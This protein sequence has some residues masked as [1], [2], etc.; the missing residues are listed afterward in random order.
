MNSDH[1]ITCEA[2]LTACRPLPGHP[3]RGIYAMEIASS[4]EW[5]SHH[6]FPPFLPNHYVDI[7]DP[8]EQK[9]ELLRLYDLE[10]RPFPH[11]RSELGLVSLARLRGASV[12]LS[13]AEAFTVL[14]Q[15]R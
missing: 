5:S 15:V 4:T 8:L 1:R 12:G 6:I 3:V 7:A 14:R 9:V 10:M 2:V 11:P 13:A